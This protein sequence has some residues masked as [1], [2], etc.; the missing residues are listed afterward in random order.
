MPMSEIEDIDSKSDLRSDFK[1]DLKIKDDSPSFSFVVDDE[2]NIDQNIEDQVKSKKADAGGQM[3]AASPSYEALDRLDKAENLPRP[4]ITMSLLS[5]LF[6][7][8]FLPFYIACI[9]MNANGL[10]HYPAPFCI[11]TLLCLPHFVWMIFAYRKLYAISAALQA[12]PR[13]WRSQA[14]FK[15][16]PFLPLVAYI[17]FSYA[18]F[19]P[20][21][22]FGLFGNNHF[23]AFSISI[24]LACIFIG[25]VGRN[26]KALKDAYKS[27]FGDRP[28]GSSAM[29]ALAMLNLSPL[30]YTPLIYHWRSWVEQMI[31]ARQEKI[32]PL[33]AAR[34]LEARNITVIRYDSFVAFSRWM[35]QRKSSMRGSKGVLNGILAAAAD[36]VLIFLFVSN[37]A[38]ISK[39]LDELLRNSHGGGGGVGGIVGDIANITYFICLGLFIMAATALA[40]RYIRRQPTNYEFGPE[41]FRYIIKR[42]RQRVFGPLHRWEDVAAIRLVNTQNGLSER[43]SVIEFHV[44]HLEPIKLKL[45]CIESIE[46][47]E[48]ILQAIEKWAPAVSRDA[49]LVQALQAPPGNS[50]TELWLQALAAPP[51]RDRLQPIEAGMMLNQQRYRVTR[52]LGV[53][54]QGA[55]YEAIDQDSQEL[56]VL[57]EFLLPIY[58]DISIRKEVLEQFE[59][60]A[61]ILKHLD[62]KQIVK[63]SSFFVEDHRAYLVLE[64]IDG[65]NLREKVKKNGP[66]SELDVLGLAEQMCN[67]LVYLHSRM[68]VVVH[69][70]FTPDNLILRK[71]GLLKLIDFNVARQ[72]ES[73]ATGSVVGKP[74]YLPPEQF[75]GE[76]CAQSDIYALGASLHYLLTGQDPEPIS[77][78]HPRTL[79][80]E[81][82]VGLDE[83]V[84]RATASD[85]SKRYASAEALLIDLRFLIDGVPRLD[86]G[87]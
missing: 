16:A 14:I 46:D 12:T 6:G 34:D 77:A 78:S 84:A 72:I 7:Y 10:I 20:F 1:P 42:R 44:R 66:L 69:R 47:R 41:G 2:E 39:F 27:E 48:A 38:S 62:H 60:E 3:S 83:L 54:G 82:G 28:A 58:V 55:A 45:G 70:D 68:P 23:A 17:A 11:A 35:R 40:F 74:A 13:D 87:N 15:V 4:A 25:Q 19:Q 49:S 24:L 21:H 81:I 51:Q 79:R 73:T 32:A 33:K 85:L 18:V 52:A 37:Q 26:I 8:F 22:R 53:G 80:P 9:A 64:H 36:L 61:R 67:I 57:K 50:Y 31:A 75:R 86:T 76:P 71:D 43:D 5:C 56:V 30:G 65:I 29:R 59:S 63:L